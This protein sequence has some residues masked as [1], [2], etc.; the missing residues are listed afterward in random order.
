MEYPVENRKRQR[1]SVGVGLFLTCMVLTTVVGL[2]AGLMISNYTHNNYVM[3]AEKAETAPVQ[4]ELVRENATAAPAQNSGESEAKAGAVSAFAENSQFTKAQIVEMSAPSVVG[5]DTVR[6][7][8]E[9]R[10]PRQRQRRDPHR[11]RLYRHLRP[12]GGRGQVREGH[13]ERRHL[14]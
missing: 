13:P 9:L 3:Y 6:L 2:F 12:C 7:R 10:G 8:P 11:G 1:L 5:I 14:L 4:R